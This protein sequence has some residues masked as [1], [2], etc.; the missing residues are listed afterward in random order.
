[1]IGHD[2]PYL[3]TRDLNLDWLLKNMKQILADWAEYQQTMN[4]N[5]ADLQAAVNQFETDIT[6][7]F[8][9]LHDYVE[10]YFDNLDVQQEIN[11]KLNDM[12]LSGELAQ[13]MNPL[14]ATETG[15]WLSTHITNPSNPP[16]DTSL[17]VSNAAA[18]AKVTGDKIRSNQ[19]AI[20]RIIDVDAYDSVELFDASTAVDGYYPA[21]Y[22]GDLV[23]NADTCAS[24]FI[25]VAGISKLTLLGTTSG[26]HSVVFYDRDKTYIAGFNATLTANTPFYYTIPY[27]T[28]SDIYFM[29]VGANISEKSAYSVQGD[30]SYDWQKRFGESFVESVDFLEGFTAATYSSVM[31]ITFWN[32]NYLPMQ[33]CEGM[34]LKSVTLAFVSDNT[35]LTFRGYDQSI[36]YHDLTLAQIRA[37]A[38]LAD[39]HGYDLFR[40]TNS[41]AGVSTYLLDGSDDRVEII[42]D[43]LK[44]PAALG[45]NKDGDTGRFTYYNSNVS[46]GNVY[47]IYH[48]I[49]SSALRESRLGLSF[50]IQYEDGLALNMSSE[51]A[52]KK[53]FEISIL[54]K[55]VQRLISQY[56]NSRFAGKK[57]NCLGDSITYGYI[58]D[59]G[60]QMAKPY[61][62]TVKEILG[63][64]A[65]R[66]Y[67]ISGSTLAVNDGDY[68]PMCVRYANMDDDADIILVFG[69]TNDYGRA[70]YTPSIGTITDAVNTTVYGALNILCEGLISKYPQ[71][72]IFLCTP[73]KR[74]DKTAPNGGGYTLE[75][76]ADAIRNVGHKFGMPVLDLNYQ[77]GFYIA[78]ADFRAEYGGEDKLH[79]NQ[80]FDNEHLGPMIAR[81]IDGLI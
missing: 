14:I 36:P 31:S 23:A 72:L 55:D 7:A 50:E 8:D 16:I 33:I 2:F 32:T 62:D 39:E 10:D 75:D 70:V 22:S 63:L 46:S 79:P 68:S 73:L 67:G 80:A 51:K 13:I 74:A 4:Q 27:N 35:T 81:F 69:G 48:N 45:I 44:C 19:S 60:A 25:Y 64:A 56:E 61:P 3:D 65:C 42:A 26:A 76:V 11:N 40:I 30:A 49:S 77:G 1:M 15:T 18:D 66:N 37:Y 57:M 28:H 41:T 9:N 5:F 34:T 17:S 12:K 43:S 71:A 52:G 20:T 38:D 78:N 59:S 6:T 21:A 54:P 47:F 24:D 29:R 58:P 53:V